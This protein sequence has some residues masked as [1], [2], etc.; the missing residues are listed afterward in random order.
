MPDGVASSEAVLKFIAEE[1]SADSY[2]NIMAQYRPEYRAFDAPEISRKITQK[3]FTE[4]IQMAKR[5]HLYRGF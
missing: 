3:E 1:V 2:V 5:F 4:T